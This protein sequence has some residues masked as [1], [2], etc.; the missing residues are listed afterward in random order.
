[1]LADSVTEVEYDVPDGEEP[2]ACPYCGRPFS[3][4]RYRAF[5]VGVRHRDAATEAERNVFEAERDDEEFDLFT[6]HVKITVLVM[7]TY[8]TFTFFYALSLG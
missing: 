6:F 3:S 1:M 2:L 4:E 5:H 8:F 7:V